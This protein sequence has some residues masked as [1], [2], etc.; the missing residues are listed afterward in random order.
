M[1]LLMMVFDVSTGFAGAAMKGNISSSV[2][3]AGIFHKIGFIVT[4]MLAWFAETA[5]AL[6]PSIGFD[7]PIVLPW[8]CFI[9]LT[10][11]VSV[12]ENAAVMNPELRN[13]PIFKL[14]NRGDND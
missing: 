3:R 1:A 12:L 5:T 9:I 11:I 8:C 6:V 2:M 14:L 7:Y 4:I 10:E 13:T